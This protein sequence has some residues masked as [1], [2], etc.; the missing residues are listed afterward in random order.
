[1]CLRGPPRIASGRRLRHASKGR[2]PA[3]RDS[4]SSPPV[5]SNGH[6]AMVRNE[7]VHGQ[8]ERIIEAWSNRGGGRNLDDGYK[9]FLCA[10]LTSH[11]I[12][13]STGGRDD[14]GGIT[15]TFLLRKY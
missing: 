4:K 7:T 10:N 14:G 6:T 2:Y 13:V 9:K 8:V 11:S 12:T 15:L 3:C 5:S 1:M